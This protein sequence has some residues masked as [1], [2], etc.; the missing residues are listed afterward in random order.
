[1][2]LKNYIILRPLM[3]EKMS[4]LEES[5][6]KYAFE[7]HP[8]ANKLEI[9]AA[10]EDKFGVKV[11]KVATSNRVGKAK[12][13][14]TRSGGRTIRTQGRRS[15]WKRAIVTLAEGQKIDLFSPEGAG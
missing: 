5:Q 6:R 11:L 13:M 3:T 1:M 9:K 7:V 8:Q 2:T 14:T 15:A 4:H 12:G 10:V